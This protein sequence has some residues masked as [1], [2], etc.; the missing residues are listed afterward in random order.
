MVASVA[1]FS[2]IKNSGFK[3][4]E[5][6]KACKQPII[7]TIL[8]NKGESGVANVQTLSFLKINMLQ[9]LRRLRMFRFYHF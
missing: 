8:R 4:F 7:Y 3:Y 6:S 5:M 1:K 9:G 2:N